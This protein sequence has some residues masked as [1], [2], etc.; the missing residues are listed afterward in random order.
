VNFRDTDV[1]AC[2]KDPTT[3]ESNAAGKKGIIAGK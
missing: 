3:S 1:F 2:A